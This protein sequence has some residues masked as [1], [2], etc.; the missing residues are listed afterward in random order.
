ML[1]SLAVNCQSL[2]AKRESFMNL[3]DTYNPDIIFGTESWLK[4]DILSSE[5]FPIGYSVYRCD[6][7]DGYGGVFIACHESLISCCLEIDGNLCELV[8]CEVK[9]LNNSNLI[10]CSA[11]CL[12]SSSDEYLNK[13]CDHLEFIKN[14]HPNSAIWIAGDTYK[15]SRY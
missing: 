1:T 6:R 5:V 7:A 3:I 13:L 10:V 8:A 12:P 4:S 2:L 9:L 14:N 11:Y 15:P